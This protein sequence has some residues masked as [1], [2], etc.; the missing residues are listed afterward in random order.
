M[1]GVFPAKKMVCFTIYALARA[2][3]TG[4]RPG[5]VNFGTIS[6]KKPPHHDC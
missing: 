6:A 2:R 5:A 1:H 3:L 4:V